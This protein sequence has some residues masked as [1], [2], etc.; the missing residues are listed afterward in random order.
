MLAAAIALLVAGV[1]RAA[2]PPGPVAVSVGYHASDGCPPRAV[3]VEQLESR[4]LRVT[5]PD[6]ARRLT[7]DVGRA[8]APAAAAF[9]GRMAVETPDAPTLS[10]AVTGQDCRAVVLSLA[11][12]AALALN[13]AIDS[14]APPPATPA[15][16]TIAAAA[17]E[18]PPAGDRPRWWV[19]AAGRGM[20]ALGAGPAL[21]FAA[22]AERAWPG[23][24]GR[25][26]SLAIAAA[27]ASPATMT[28]A[29]GSADL[30]AYLARVDACWLGGLHAAPAFLLSPCAGVEGGVVQGS[31]SIARPS[32]A[33]RPWIAP[34]LS[35]RAALGLTRRVW[36]SFAGYAF[37]PLVRDT[38]VFDDP[39]ATIHRTPVLGGGLEVGLAAAF[40]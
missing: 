15:P 6:A 5:A 30:R 33:T 18:I 34:A 12:V 24:S 4:G 38:F 10:R 11:L 2:D 26:V 39:R 14:P 40:R 1:A 19:G 8:A 25:G 16:D 21:G 17:P 31:G 29:S 35:A 3:V 28:V 9:T 37:A 23:E 36:V 20:S 13:P 27:T 22:F 32:T 7:I